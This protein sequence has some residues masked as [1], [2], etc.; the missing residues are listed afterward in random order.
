MWGT[1]A[2]TNSVRQQVSE[3]VDKILSRKSAFVLGLLLAAFV[4]LQS[5][6]PL[7]TAIRIGADEDGELSKAT[8][9]IHGLSLGTPRRGLGIVGRQFC[10]GNIHN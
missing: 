3:A 8:L 5:L 1:P 10:Q 9:C 7:G 6:L 2:L 4:G